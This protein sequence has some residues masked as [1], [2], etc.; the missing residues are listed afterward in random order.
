MLD[1]FISAW[2]NAG[3]GKFIFPKEVD[4]RRSY[5]IVRRAEEKEYPWDYP[6]PRVMINTEG[7]MS[8]SATSSTP[9]VSIS[10]M[11]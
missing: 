8:I 9:Y 4:C 3:S 6:Y 7:T 2:N 5:A 11:G 1:L 10:F